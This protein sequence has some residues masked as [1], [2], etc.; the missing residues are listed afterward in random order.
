MKRTFATAVLAAAV[1]HAHAASSVLISPIDPVLEADQRATALW[2]E[3][4]GAEPVRLQLRIFAWSQ[5]GKEDQYAQQQEIVGSPPMILIEPGK[6]QLVR[7][8]RLV[9]APDATERAYR[10]VIDEIPAGNDAASG[11]ASGASSADAP[12]SQPNGQSTGIKF[13]MRYAVPLFSYGK[14]LWAKEDPQKKRDPAS[15]G[16]P[17]LSWRQ[18]AEGGRQYLEIANQGPVHAR[19]THVSIEQNGKQVE[20]AGGLFGYVLAHSTMRWPMPAQVSAAGGA[21]SAD[22]NGLNRQQTIPHAR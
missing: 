19:L 18:V 13:Q 2:L 9:A 11:A 10:V 12:S 20:I 6:K 1:S 8:T 4:R 7:V 21:L 5:E 17:D 16:K 14:N 3:N 22:V 15:A